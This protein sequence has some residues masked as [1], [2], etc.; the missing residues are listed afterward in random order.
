VKKRSS[1]PRLTMKSLRAIGRS[2]AL[3][4]ACQ[5]VTHPVAPADALALSAVVDDNA[6]ARGQSALRTVRLPQRY[7]DQP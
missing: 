1:S 3:Q 2:N 5:Q 6:H 7:L 4:R